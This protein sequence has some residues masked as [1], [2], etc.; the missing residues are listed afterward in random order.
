[1]NNTNHTTGLRNRWLRVLCVV[2]IGGIFFAY[3]LGVGHYRWPPFGLIY[4]AKTTVT[5]S[6]RASSP[7][8]E[9]LGE[10]ELLQYAFTDP[11]S[12][13]DLYY[14]PITSLEGIRDANQRIFM[15]RN[16]FETAYR[17]LV[18][19]GAQQV[20]RPVGVQPVV[21]VNFRHQGR[22]YEAFAYGHL[23]ASCDSRTTASLIIPG[24][25]LNQSLVIVTNDTANYH[26][27]ILEALDER[28][29][30]TFILIKPN[31]DFLAWHDGKGKKLS[32]DFIWNWHLNRDGSYSVSYIVKSLAFTKWMQGCYSQSIVAGL[33]QGGA[34]A[35]MNAIQS[36]P[37]IA[38]VSSGTSVLNSLA[39]WS[40][41]G[42]Q[43][44]AVPGFGK[45][46]S[47]DYLFEQLGSSKTQWFFS[48]GRAETGTYKIEAEERITA[49][50]I[51][52]LPNVTVVIHDGGHIFP[53]VD[54]RELLETLEGTAFEDGSGL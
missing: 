40:G 37:D 22:D 32:G 12:E 50:V 29:G 24:S 27:G 10:Q 33:S 54:I 36:R 15:L 7:I 49:K 26:H 39:E 14:P 13:T 16:D 34:A 4:E 11:L 35:F 28:G 1:M 45:L 31:E 53:L 2:A 41:A 8:T 30:E 23:P 25:G 47:K 20:V 9:Y 19:L 46:S 42:T 21:K 18:V 3:G 17:D 51:E 5:Q 6:L 38:V 44:H 52:E 48:W 43:L